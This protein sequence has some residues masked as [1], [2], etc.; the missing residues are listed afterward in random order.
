MQVEPRDQINAL[1]HLYRGE[2]QRMTMYRVRL[3]STT[4]WAVGTT[5]AI[6]SF[7]LGN[8]SLPHWIFALALA[9]DLMFLRLEAQRYQLYKRLY[10]RVRIFEE[11]FFPELL[12]QDGVSNW[13]KLLVSSLRSPAVDSITMLQ[14]IAVRLRRVYLWLIIAVYAGWIVK[15][16]QAGHLPEAATVGGVAGPIAFWLALTPLLAAAVIA[17]HHRESE[18]E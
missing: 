2:L 16:T 13:E 3:D 9:L 18:A 5:A 7:A 15:L 14:A 11:G 1:V 12:Q 10:R 17:F 8:A 4:N 6:L